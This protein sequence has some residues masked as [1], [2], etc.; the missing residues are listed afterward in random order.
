MR[1]DDA[2]RKEGIEIPF[3]QHD[4]HMAPPPSTDTE[5]RDSGDDKGRAGG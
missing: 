1:V 4:V 3:P 5:G 2:F